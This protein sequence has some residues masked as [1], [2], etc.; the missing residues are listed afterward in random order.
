MRPSVNNSSHSVA[1]LSDR[2]WDDISVLAGML[3]ATAASREDIL[4][5]LSPACGEREKLLVGLAEQDVEA[6][7]SMLEKL[8]LPPD[9]NQSVAIAIAARVSM[10]TRSRLRSRLSCE[11]DAALRIGELDLAKEILE[12]IKQLL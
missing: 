2:Q 7:S 4:A 10:E 12:R 5:A 1:R 8:G 11:L 6:F 3:L 9:T